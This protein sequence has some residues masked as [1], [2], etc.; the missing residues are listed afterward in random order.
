VAFLEFQC[1]ATVV[2]KFFV[3]AWSSESDRTSG[4]AIS[5][6]GDSYLAYLRHKVQLAIQRTGATNTV[7]DKSQKSLVGLN[8]GLGWWHGDVMNVCVWSSS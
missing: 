6:G 2:T 8:F 7:F 5:V 3:T 4:V 1:E